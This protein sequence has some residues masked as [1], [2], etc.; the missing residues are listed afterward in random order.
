MV[1]LLTCCG[2]R[3]DKTNDVKSDVAWRHYNEAR[4]AKNL[5]LTL[6]VID[7]ME[8]AKIV[9]TAKA[10]RLRGLAYDQGWQMRVAEHYYKK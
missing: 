6:A 9:S 8:R 4:Q 2:N 5:E 1:A 7:S 3:D 10:D